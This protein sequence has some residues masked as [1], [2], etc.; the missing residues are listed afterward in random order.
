MPRWFRCTFDSDI[1]N[2][3]VDNLHGTISRRLLGF[4]TITS[5]D[6]T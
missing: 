5:G 6:G 4:K 2:H 3:M 1:K